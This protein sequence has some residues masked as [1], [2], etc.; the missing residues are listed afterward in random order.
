MRKLVLFLYLSLQFSLQLSAQS[1]GEN[2][3]WDNLFGDVKMKYVYSSYYETYLPKPRFGSSLE[4]LEGKEITL[5]GF[6]LPVDVTGDVFVVSYNPMNMC[7]FCTGSGIESIIEV[8]VRD[9]Q[10]RHFGKLK[11]DNYIK[12]KGILHLN[13]DDFE[14]LIYILNKAELV[15][16]IK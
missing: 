13:V 6:F 4:A 11:A 5:K 14:H 16:V 10:L 2:N 12:V 1:P 15:E 8:N 7:F 9:E 3:I